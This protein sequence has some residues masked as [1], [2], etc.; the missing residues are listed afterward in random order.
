MARWSKPRP[1]LGAVAAAGVPVRVSPRH[2]SQRQSWPAPVGVPAL[3]AGLCR[4]RLQR[5]AMR[6]VRAGNGVGRRA[7]HFV[8]PL[9]ARHVRAQSGESAVHPVSARHVREPDGRCGVLPVPA[10]PAGACV[11]G[12]GDRVRAVP[13]R[14]RV[15]R[16][17]RRQLRGMRSVELHG[18]HGRHG[19]SVVSPQHAVVRQVGDG[20]GGLP[21]RGG[22][23][24]RARR[25]VLDVSGRR[26]LRRHDGQP[27]DCHRGLLG[28]RRRS[29]HVLPVYAAGGMPW[30]DCPRQRD[31]C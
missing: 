10:G 23:L 7:K 19:V 5:R 11:A 8:R 29:F 25:P 18:Q 21:V 31:L 13:A 30:Q 4:R 28:V 9:P 22:L 12:S 15:R 16:S 17:R 27:A 14:Y 20:S 6:S 1:P 24:W 26:I 2:V 3:R